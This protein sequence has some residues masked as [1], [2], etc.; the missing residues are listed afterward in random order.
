MERVVNNAK[1]LVSKKYKRLS[2]GFSDDDKKNVDAI[3]SFIENE[4]LD[5]YPQVNFVVYDTSDGV[6][7][8]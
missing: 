2:I 1:Y 5:R 4:L 8:S 3:K 7:I 6:K